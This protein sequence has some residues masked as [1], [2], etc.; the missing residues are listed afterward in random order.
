M[1]GTVLMCLQELVTKVA[2]ASAWK[3]VLE[4]GGQ[5]AYAVF[6]ASA[7]V[8]DDAT[9]ALLAATC[10]ELNLTV[11]QAGD[12]F[13][14]YWVNTYSSK[15]YGNF[16][17]RHASA[18]TFLVELNEMHARLTRQLPGARPPKFSFEWRSPDALIMTYDSHRSLIDVAVGMVRGLSKRFGE[19]LEV[20]KLSS[21]TLEVRFPAQ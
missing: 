5:S 12:A 20:T 13:G 18:R 17:A 21:T 10:A 8:D 9:A 15:L 6:T 7:D 4:R 16:Y 2:G 1:K 14:D 19:A 11:E 3:R